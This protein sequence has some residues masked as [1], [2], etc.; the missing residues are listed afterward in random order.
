[1]KHSALLAGLGRISLETLVSQ[2]HVWLAADSH[3]VLVLL[4]RFPVL[5]LLFSSFIFIC[6][7]HEIHR[8]TLVLTSYAVPSDWQMVA[9]NL[10]VFTAIL[11]P[12]GIHD[13]MFY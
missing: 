13:G 3:G 10:L 4:P 12:I 9:R 8:L 5:N 11:V 7:S 2:G 1:G 6:A